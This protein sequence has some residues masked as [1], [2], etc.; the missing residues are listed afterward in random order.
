MNQSDMKM[1]GRPRS[2]ENCVNEKSFCPWH[3]RSEWIWN[4]S[5][6]NTIH[7]LHQ[8]FVVGI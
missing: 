4:S 1:V 3:S 8:I 5:C 2:Q 7:L 6:Y